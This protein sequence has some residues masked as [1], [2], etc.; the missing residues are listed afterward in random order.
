M[1]K[2]NFPQKLKYKEKEK[3]YFLIMILFEIDIKYLI[4][5]IRRKNE[6]IREVIFLIKF[7]SLYFSFSVHPFSMTDHY[8]CL[9]KKCAE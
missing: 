8:V 2:E 3:K 5:V 6:I 9:N 4:A 1:F 7:V